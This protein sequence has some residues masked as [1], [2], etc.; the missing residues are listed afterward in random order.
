MAYG[1]YRRSLI[2]REPAR[3]TETARMQEADAVS[4]EATSLEEWED[5]GGA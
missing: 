4:L 2:V 5:E 1:A 3:G